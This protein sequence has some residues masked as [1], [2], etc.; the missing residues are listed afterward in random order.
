[1]RT[2][3]PKVTFTIKGLIEIMYGVPLSCSTEESQHRLLWDH[4]EMQKPLSSE[5]GMKSALGVQRMYKKSAPGSQNVCLINQPWSFTFFSQL[6]FPTDGLLKCKCFIFPPTI[7]I[8]EKIANFLLL[9]HLNG[10]HS[11]F[12]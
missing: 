6:D 4:W 1:M 8:E 5:G 12:P 2:Q 11:F 7:S 3:E 9:S 10:T